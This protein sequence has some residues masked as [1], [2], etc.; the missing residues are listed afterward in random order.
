MSHIYVAY[1]RADAARVQ[2]LAT[3]LEN[4]GL[5]VWFDQKLPG[6]ELW[7]NELEHQH[8]TA[9]CVLVVWSRASTGD[10]NHWVIEE[11]NP[12]LRSGK[13][14]QVLIDNVQPP[15]GFRELQAL[16]LAHWKGNPRDVAF[17]DVVDAVNAKIL[18]Q[19]APA[20]RWP[21]LRLRRMVARTGFS[22]VG[23]AMLLSLAFNTFGAASRVCSLQQGLADFCG[24]IHLGGQ[25]TRPERLAWEARPRGSCEALAAHV[26][27]FPDGAYAQEAANLIAAKHV[28]MVTSWERT[29][30]KLPL[31]ASADGAPAA[32][33][34]AAR[35]DALARALPAAQ[36]QCQG[37][38][39]GTLYRFQGARVAPANWTCEHGSGG[40][41]CGFDGDAVCVLDLKQTREEATCGG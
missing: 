4:A 34:A 16:D 28:R 23:A 10:D 12:A 8:S 1:K 19:P 27:R 3:A 2:Q 41:S 21:K 24:E 39:S 31:Y 32:S 25:P 6:A 40:V 18:G 30:R 36:R 20:P 17:Q 7:R 33:E 5:D 26:R 15:F 22:G 14:V 13:L 11:A 37:F 38:G 29:E 9:G 35:S